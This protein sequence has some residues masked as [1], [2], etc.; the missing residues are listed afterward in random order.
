VK[1]AIPSAV[2]LMAFVLG[3]AFLG[4]WTVPIVA[5]VW[6][7]VATYAL[8][9]WRT[10]AA[11]AALAWALLLVVSGTRGSL[12]QLAGLLGGIFGL[13]GFAIVLLTLAFPALLA[14]SAAGLVSSLGAVLT[15]RARAA[16][17][18]T[19]G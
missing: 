8:R 16:D 13:P 5:G 4:W 9:P 17:T 18:V 1:R 3:T 19:P 12:L 11:G 15:E 14:W 6:G 2:L 7:A 10:A